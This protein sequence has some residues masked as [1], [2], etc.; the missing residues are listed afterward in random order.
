MGIIDIVV[1]VTFLTLAIIGIVKGFVKSFFSSFAWLIGYILAMILSKPLANI[2][3]GSSVGVNLVDTI[4]NWFINK[5]EI[6]SMDVSLLTNEILTE[7][8]SEIGIPS[9][10]HNLLL[11]DFNISDLN[12]CSLA[13]YLSPKITLYI[14]SGISFFVIYLLGF[15]LMKLLGK[16]LGKIVKGG[17]FNVLDRVLGCI[18]GLTKAAVFVWLFF[19]AIS[20]II[21]IPAA[22][23]INTWFSADIG[24][25]T[26]EFGLAKYLYENNAVVYIISKY[27]NL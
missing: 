19:F 17:A 14:F 10:L 23:G 5:H 21:S 20:F 27:I 2:L 4:S 25:G 15:V 22:E 11:G 13:M 8:L 24:L 3:L 1:I 18:W 7:A 6:F 26:E 16:L 9:I 12:N